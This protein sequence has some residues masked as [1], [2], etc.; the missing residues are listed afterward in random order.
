MAVPLP[1]NEKIEDPSRK[2]RSK[3]YDNDDD[4]EDCKL[5]MIPLALPIRRLL[6]LL[7]RLLTLILLLHSYYDFDDYYCDS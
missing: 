4:Y 6:V 1:T 3:K 7:I 5:I 2:R